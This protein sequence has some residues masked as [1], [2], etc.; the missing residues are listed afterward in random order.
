MD[1]FHIN[2][3][4]KRYKRS[5]DS[6]KNLVSFELLSREKDE[7]RTLHILNLRGA[8]QKPSKRRDRFVV[9]KLAEEGALNGVLSPE[10]IER[11]KTTGVL[12]PTLTVDYKIPLDLGGLATTENMYVVDKDVAVLMDKLYWHQLRL[13]VNKIREQYGQNTPKI[14]IS[15]YPLPNVFTQEDFLNYVLFY[16]RKGLSTY[17]AKRRKLIMDTPDRIVFESLP[18]GE[19]LLKLR[20]PPQLPADMKMVIVRVNPR[21]NTEQQTIRAEYIEKRPA[22]VQASLRRGDFD[23]LTP[24]D[25]K[26]IAQKGHVP[27]ILSCHHILPLH[28]GGGNEMSNIRWMDHLEHSALHQRFIAPLES[29]LFVLSDE[30]KNGLFFEM[31]VPVGAKIPTY[32]LQNGQLVPS[33]VAQKTGLK[34]VFQKGVSGRSDKMTKGSRNK[35]Y[36][37]SKFKGKTGFDDQNG[38]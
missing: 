7:K 34:P 28:L 4:Q 31:P 37:R 36:K 35:K 23:A 25:K 13:E 1:N 16:E 2:S 15:L 27:T 22:I 18:N 32:T 14:G 12:P 21:S 26:Q 8:P 29:C 6:K 11:A 38:Y 24:Q 30:V 17:L 9:K 5:K 20:N 33:G 10:A 19:S 3:Q